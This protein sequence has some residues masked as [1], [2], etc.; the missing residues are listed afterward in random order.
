MKM[1]MQSSVVIEKD[2]LL[3]EEYIQ[4]RI[5]AGWGNPE[6]EDVKTALEKSLIV[7]VKR[8]NGKAVG[9]VR[10]VGDGKLC[11]YIQ[12]LIVLRDLRKQ[13]FATELMKE[14]IRYI[15]MVAAPNAFIGLM[16]AKGLD[17]FYQKYGFI[18]RPNDQMG[19]G[20]IMFHGRKGL[21]HFT[22]G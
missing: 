22:S 11:F 4:L 1:E 6:K 19:P 7:F 20:M 14:V 13:G 18:S 3:P 21:N 8:I 15:G 9:A 12:D 10:I 16:A 5:D 17:S 2:T